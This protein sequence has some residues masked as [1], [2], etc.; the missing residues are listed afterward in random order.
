ML[1]AEAAL[2]RAVV[3]RLM[4]A[5]YDE[6]LIDWGSQLHNR[7]ALPWYLAQ[8]LRAVLADLERHGLGLGAHLEALLL[9]D[10]R[11]ELCS[12]EWAGLS[13]RVVAAQEFWPLIGD[14]TTQQPSDSRLVDASTQRIE[15]RVSA[16]DPAQLADLALQVNGYKGA[17]ADRM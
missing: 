6:P 1:S 14:V 17:A 16:S 10:S 13:I 12:L 2:L 7:F 4:H 11:R 15:L 8:D 9:D 3:A 5:P